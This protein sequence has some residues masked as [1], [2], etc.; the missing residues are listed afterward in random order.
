M[1]ESCLYFNT[2]S[3]AR[4][5][6]REW[7]KAFRPFGLTPPQ[8]FLLRMVLAEPGR[9]ARELADAMTVARPTATRLIDGL[10]E[11]G[12]LE[13]RPSPKDGR[14]WEIHPSGSATKLREDL[15]AASADVTRRLRGVLGDEGFDETVSRLRSARAVVG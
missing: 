3:L 1:F 13:R 5:L 4:L 12:L 8:A 15:N 10:E 9:L 7:S 11:K 2:T 6:E 14:E